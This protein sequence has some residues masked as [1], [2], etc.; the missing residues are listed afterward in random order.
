MKYTIII[1]DNNYY[2][3]LDI[4]LQLKYAFDKKNIENEV[5]PYQDALK[6]KLLMNNQEHKCIFFGTKY[7][8][9]ELPKNSILTD[10]D[11]DKIF[12]KHFT[13]EMV[14]NHTIVSYSRITIEKIRNQ[15]NSFNVGMF[16]YGYCGYQDLNLNVDKDI[17]VCYLGGAEDRRKN[18]MTQL[19]QN[20]KCVYTYGVYGED[21]QKLYSRSKIILSIYSGDYLKNFSSG[22]RIFPAVSNGGFVISEKCLDEEQDN[23]LSKICV[24]T[25]YENLINLIKYYLTFDKEREKLRQQ[26]YEN[27]KAME[28]KL[29]F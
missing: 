14:D 21:R 16:Y 10:F 6:R 19:S 26:F 12:E 5:M 29:V 3:Y 18:I 2:M 23:I 22:S 24:N 20:F 17:D 11:N 7:N 25:N 9:F 8:N 15:Y 27:I 1:L 28:C 4:V 13:K